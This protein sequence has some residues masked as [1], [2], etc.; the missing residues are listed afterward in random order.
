WDYNFY[1]EY[2]YAKLK[3]FSYGAG[4]KWF[5]SRK[6]SIAP[7]GSYFGIGL[8]RHNYNV[9]HED[10]ILATDDPGY[11]NSWGGSNDIISL[12]NR[13]VDFS[14]LTMDFEFGNTHQ[15][16]KDIYYKL[17]LSSSLNFGLG[18]LDLNSYDDNQTSEDFLVQNAK[19]S[20]K[21][22]N[23]LVLKFGLGMVLH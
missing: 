16:T 21:Y 4:V 8:T 14:Y 5:R 7:I 9:T 17:G 10:M 19:E 11:N 13:E 1:E 22:S 3:G 20:L 2:G 6:A 18:T 15:I 23:L 12:D